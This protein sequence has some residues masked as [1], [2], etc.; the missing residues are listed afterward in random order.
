MLC[1]H[2]SI[3]IFKSKSFFLNSNYHTTTAKHFLF[4]QFFTF[5]VQFFTFFQINLIYFLFS[6]KFRIFQTSQ[7]LSNSNINS[8]CEDL[9]KIRFIIQLFRD[10]S[11]IFSLKQC[12]FLK[13]ILSILVLEHMT[14][15]DWEFIFSDWLFVQLNSIQELF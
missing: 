15:I 11:S 1:P 4:V 9:K 13:N 5:F 14:W 10:F 3:Y 8:I 6:S 2:V 7:P 12:K